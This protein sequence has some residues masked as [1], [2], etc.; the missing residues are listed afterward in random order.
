MKPGAPAVQLSSMALDP[1]G[2]FAYATDAGA[3]GLQVFQVNGLT[4][5]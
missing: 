2:R 1:A 4:A 3:S 5:C